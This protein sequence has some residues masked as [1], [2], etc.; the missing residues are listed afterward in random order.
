MIIYSDANETHFHKKDLAP[1]FVLK[2]RVD[3]FATYT[4]IAIAF[5]H[6][7][8][9]LFSGLKTKIPAGKCDCYTRMLQMNLP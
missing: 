7:N 6:W 3:S 4:R 1:S 8:F 5:A 2:L 9:L